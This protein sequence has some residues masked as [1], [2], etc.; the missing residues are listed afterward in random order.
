M[1]ISN[2]TMF[3]SCSRIGKAKNLKENMVEKV[4]SGMRI[5][6]AADDAAGISISESFKAQ[7]RGLSQAERNIQDGISLLQVSDGALQDVQKHLQRMKELAVHASNGTL[8]DEDRKC[9]DEEFLQIKNSIDSIAEN[10]EFNGIKLLKENKSIKIQISDKPFTYYDLNLDK[11]DIEALNIKDS[12]LSNKTYAED[13]LQKIDR[14]ILKL[15]D[16]LNSIGASTNEL[17]HALTNTTN[18][19]INLSSSLSRIKD[20]DM[21]SSVM[22]MVKSDVITQYSEFMYSVS[23]QDIESVKKFI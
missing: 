13:S 17:K 14:S 4:S 11:L 8:T 9:I 19:N 7:V 10:T 1:L 5:N 15:N 21:A 22:N 12:N 20:A 6:K 2:T 23:K 16:S 18:S 3:F